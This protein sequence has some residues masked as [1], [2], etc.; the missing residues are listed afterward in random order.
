MHH[1]LTCKSRKKEK[2]LK[3][4][5]ECGNGKGTVRREL[6]TPLHAEGHMGRCLSDPSLSLVGLGEQ[7]QSLPFPCGHAG[8]FRSKVAA[9][10]SCV[11]S[12]L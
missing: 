7:M 6:L 8:E 10:S 11:T 2:K 3:W 4:D 12:T 9:I 5:V 1:V